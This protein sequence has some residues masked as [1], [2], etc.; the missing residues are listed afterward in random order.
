MARFGSDEAGFS[1]DAIASSVKVR[2][3]G[4]WDAA[5]AARFPPAVFEALAAAGP[6]AELL[7]DVTELKPQREAGQAALHEVI[8]GTVRLGLRRAELVVTNAITRMQ[9]A[10]IVREAGARSWTL[11]APIPPARPNGG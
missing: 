3:W 2:A 9:L 4:F 8:E 11:S 6:R 1:I 7:V 10:R 5:T